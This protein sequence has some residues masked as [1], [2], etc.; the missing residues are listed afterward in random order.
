LPEAIQHH[1]SRLAFF[2]EHTDAWRADVEENAATLEEARSQPHLLAAADVARVK[3]VYTEQ[4]DDLVLFE[5][6]AARWRSQGGLTGRQ[7]KNLKSLD[8]NLARLRELNAQILA[9]ADA[10][11]A[12]TIETVLP[13]SDLE[14]GMAALLGQRSGG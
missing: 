8:A 3:R 6:T 14:L 10:L 4:V 12:G 13:A 5:Q 11:A 2:V 1:I 7:E 9:L